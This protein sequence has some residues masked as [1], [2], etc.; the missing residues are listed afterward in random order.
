MR[1][2]IGGL[3]LAAIVGGVMLLMSDDAS[4]GASPSPTPTP[5]VNNDA[6]PK[7]KTRVSA[8]FIPQGRAIPALVGSVQPVVGHSRISSGF[9]PRTLRGK[10]SNHGGIDI[11]AA[12]GTRVVAPVDGTVS[13]VHTDHKTCGRGIGLNTEFARVWMC[14]FSEVMVKPGQKVKKGQTIARVG[15]TGNTTA[16]HLH[17]SVRYFLNG[18][19]QAVDPQRTAE[20][21]LSKK[22]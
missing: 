3:V 19:W 10:P 21:I 11:P 13:W 1:L 14:H 15:D 7:I 12:H 2:L 20:E 6:P 22:G 16:S 9:G 4:A 5:D 18:R 17:M 8:T